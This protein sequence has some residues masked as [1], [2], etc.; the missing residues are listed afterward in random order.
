MREINNRQKVSNFI[1]NWYQYIII[2]IATLCFFIILNC[3]PL[4]TDTTAN[5]Y[6]LSS[7]SQ[8]LSAL[9]A[10][11]FT[12]VLITIQVFNK[13]KA[14]K[15]IVSWQTI[16]LIIVFGLGIVLPLITLRYKATLFLINIS[17]SIALFCI[18][19]LIPYV[20]KF[21]KFISSPVVYGDL[22]EHILNACNRHSWGQAISYLDDFT[23]IWLEKIRVNDQNSWDELLTIWENIKLRQRESTRLFFAFFKATISVTQHYAKKKHEDYAIKVYNSFKLDSNN[24]FLPHLR[25]ATIDNDNIYRYYTEKSLNILAMALKNKFNELSQNVIKTLGKLALRKNDKQIINELQRINNTIVVNTLKDDSMLAYLD[26]DKNSFDR[27]NSWVED[28][29]QN[30]NSNENKNQFNKSN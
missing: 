5:Y 13:F 2:I 20:L 24:L 26:R 7:I 16:I 12:V 23:N 6:I 27:L 18:F 19:S 30:I 15:L 3:L 28:C 11:V 1:K 4:P 25:H 22:E 14:W 8:G 17:I 29:K 21:G 9:L 10:I